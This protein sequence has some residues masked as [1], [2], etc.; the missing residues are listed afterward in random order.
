MRNY[1]SYCLTLPKDQS[2]F[3]LINLGRLI[4]EK[5]QKNPTALLSDPYSEIM[6]SIE[7]A[8]PDDRSQLLL[9]NVGILTEPELALNPAKIF[10]DLAVQFDVTILWTDEIIDNR[11]LVWAHQNARQI[12]EFPQ[13]TLH[14]METSA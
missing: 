1:I 9:S 8:N 10:L 13:N 11:I 5:Y 2:E 4:S 7:E 6:S 14:K 3:V 12:I